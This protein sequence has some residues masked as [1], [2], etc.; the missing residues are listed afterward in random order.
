VNI[1]EAIEQLTA[2]AE[3]LPDGLESQVKVHLCHG[4][5]AEGVITAQVEVYEAGGFAAVRGHPHLDEGNTVVR[6]L[7]MG[8]DAELARIAAGRPV[9]PG[10]P[11]DAGDGTAIRMPV[12]DRQKPMLPGSPGALAEGCTCD[13]GLN[14]LALKMARTPDQERPPGAEVQLTFDP[15][16]PFHT[17]MV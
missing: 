5:H 8:V 6:P 14:R 4:D 9:R 3:E 10:F 13:P 17:R 7:L 2:V 11:L 16:C 12:D 1:R 15:D